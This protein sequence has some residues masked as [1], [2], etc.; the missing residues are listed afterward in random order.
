MWLLVLA[1]IVIVLFVIKELIFPSRSKDKKEEE[2]RRKMHD[3]DEGL[4]D[5]DYLDEITGR[6]DKPWM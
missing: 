3:L 4:E 2:Y 1:V 5:Y 6:D